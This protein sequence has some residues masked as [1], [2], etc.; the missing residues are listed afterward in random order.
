MI[1]N[2][3]GAPVRNEDLFGRDDFI[4]V[5]WDKLK[6]TNILLVAPRRFGKTSIMYNLLDHPRDNYR[7]IHLD[8]ERIQAPINFIVELLEQINKDLILSKYIVD[9][10]KKLGKYFTENIQSFG[11]DI[12]GFGFKVE[13]K[14][15]IKDNWI[16][17]ADEVLQS[18]RN[19]GKKIIFIFDE[20]AYML[21]HFSENDI[22]NQLIISFLYWFR[23]F[24]Q[25]G[26]IEKNISFLLGSSIGIEQYLAM[27]NISAVVNDL[28]RLPLNELTPKQAKEFVN[29]LCRSERLILSA[30]SKELMLNLI[31]PPIPYFIQIFFSELI[32]E[33][34]IKKRKIKPAIVEQIYFEIILGV[35]SKGY[36]LHYYER[37]LHYSKIDEKLSKLF[38]KQLCLKE[39]LPKKYLFNLFEKER[40]IKDIESFN[41]LLSNL[42]NDYYIKYNPDEDS[43]YFASN[44]LKDW[45]RRYYG[46]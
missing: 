4:N 28:E 40:K 15:K 19:S 9:P 44:I 32:K 37:L 17:F 8:L 6:A 3:V 7:V 12:E 26:T 31:G 1:N 16:D 38:L 30:K 45:W 33:T 42:E 22:S 24:R 35:S 14:K 20:F 5:L 23:N 13:L 25:A 10:I 21:E 11:L 46:L 34:R 41:L 27:R 36:F 39:S 43:F 18:L 29:A 2:I